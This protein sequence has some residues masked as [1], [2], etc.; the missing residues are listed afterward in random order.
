MVTTFT[1]RIRI[2]RHRK[3]TKERREAQCHN[4][5]GQHVRRDED[6]GGYAPG[7][8]GR[9]TGGW[10]CDCGG[11]DDG[12]ARALVGWRAAVRGD[13]GNGGRAW[14]SMVWS[15]GEMAVG[16]EGGRGESERT[17]SRTVAAQPIFM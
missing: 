13:G 8:G 11:G 2:D 9:K 15:M 6:G 12:P 4:I 17:Q 14:T 5:R 3:Q 16:G 10:G 1:F 7:A